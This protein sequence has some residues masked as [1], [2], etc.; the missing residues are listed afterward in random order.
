[1]ISV[2]DDAVRQSLADQKDSAIE[3][4]SE[5]LAIPIVSSNPAF[6]ADVRRGLSGLPMP[7][8]KQAWR[9]SEHER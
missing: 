3:R 4:L 2:D 8:G 9:T 7:S 5:F 1:M 6:A